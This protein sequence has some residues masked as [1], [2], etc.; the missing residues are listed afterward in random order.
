MMGLMKMK[1]VETRVSVVPKRQDLRY[2]LIKILQARIVNLEIHKR[3]DEKNYNII[4]IKQIE[5]QLNLKEET[6][7][8]PS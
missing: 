1:E 4:D 2:Y 5:L 3:I 7:A 8:T 6:E